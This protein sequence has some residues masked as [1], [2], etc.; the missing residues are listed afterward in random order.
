MR[1]KTIW[2]VLTLAKL[3][4][5][6]SADDTVEFNPITEG[7]SFKTLYNV[8]RYT[9]NHFE[10]EYDVYEQ[11]DAKTKSASIWLEANNKK[12][13]ERRRFL[14]LGDSQMDVE[15]PVSES[16]QQIPD[17]LSKIDKGYDLAVDQTDQL[18]DQF[19]PLRIVPETEG[20]DEL[21]LGFGPKSK[22]RFYMDAYLKKRCKQK[23]NDKL[24]Y[25]RGLSR[26]L[27]MIECR[28]WEF[29]NNVRDVR[30]SEH[31]EVK[32]KTFMFSGEPEE[33]SAAK[34]ALVCSLKRVYVD[35]G[36]ESSNSRETVL[37]GRAVP[38]Y[39][40]LE[41]DH[42][43][44]IYIEVYQFEVV[45]SLTSS[46]EFL[47]P[48]G[49][50]Y[51]IALAS[52]TLPSRSSAF[53]DMRRKVRNGYSFRATLTGPSIPLLYPL[54]LLVAFDQS[55]Q[56]LAFQKI[57]TED[58]IRSAG[59]LRR[60]VMRE[61][62]DGQSTLKFHIMH[63]TGDQVKPLAGPRY[64]GIWKS[65]VVDTISN[66]HAQELE[67]GHTHIFDPTGAIM[68]GYAQVRGVLCQVYEKRV[69]GFPPWLG[70]GESS[71][72]LLAD[73]FTMVDAKMFSI[74]FIS[75]A[76][77][78][79]L[80]EGKL[81][82][83]EVRILS[84]T[85]QRLLHRFE[86]DVFSFMWSTVSI[87]ESHEQVDLFEV[88]RECILTDLTLRHLEMK[89]ELEPIKLPADEREKITTL[90]MLRGIEKL[91]EESVSSMLSRTAF[92]ISKVQQADLKCWMTSADRLAV[93][94][95]VHELPK[96]KTSIHVIGFATDL[97]TWH[98]EYGVWSVG[99]TSS[100][101]QEC[102]SRA[103]HSLDSSLLDTQSGEVSQVYMYCPR[104][105]HCM[106]ID[107]QLNM[108]SKLLVDSIMSFPEQPA[109]EAYLVAR[110]RLE[111]HGRAASLPQSARL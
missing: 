15:L 66:Y 42:G 93:H 54:E 96:V 65:C 108:S 109:R 97:S 103:A 45:D 107:Q 104:T 57:T 69:F 111:E 76:D 67:T 92:E 28:R 25:V 9:N 83:I 4:F 84:N 31:R 7:V 35:L 34:E 73:D 68:M 3:L 49:R 26:I 72:S 20:L 95:T 11:Y 51:S 52:G 41:F 44:D 8:V 86:V 29:F 22:I 61:V 85:D 21:L 5:L 13:L 39:I 71:V 110:V 94:L 1:T 55:K 14:Y 19:K 53:S 81:M 62:Y 90:E 75:L 24:G 56:T 70:L 36:P 23:V 88:K 6:A 58:R 12:Q 17:D 40:R 18:L 78:K 2:F 37:P 38:L 60:S 80:D 105:L 87:V 50:G 102:Q 64:P 48:P 98:E 59:G 100:S 63:S 89:L 16:D 47:I 33:K 77:H 74:F 27:H 46:I 10:F 91:R 79:N 101:L 82:R 106:L 30:K 32:V 43:I 99:A